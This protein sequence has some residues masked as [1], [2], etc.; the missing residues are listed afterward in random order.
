MKTERAHQALVTG[1]K[2]ISLQ[3]AKIFSDEDKINRLKA[4][5]E[6]D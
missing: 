1:A 4:D 6:R 3:I 2:I 5:F